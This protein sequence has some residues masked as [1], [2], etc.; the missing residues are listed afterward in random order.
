MELL[1]LIYTNSELANLL[2]NGREGIDY[3]KTGEKS[4]EY[5]IGKTN[6]TVGYSSYFS[7]FG[8]GDEVYQFGESTDD[9]DCIHKKLIRKNRNR[10][11]TLGIMFFGQIKSHRKWTPSPRW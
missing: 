1:N 5:P 9:M 11:K 2:Q 10:S 3:V 8:D 4:I 6:S 7:C